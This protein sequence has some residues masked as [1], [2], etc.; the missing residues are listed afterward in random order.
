MERVIEHIIR[1]YVAAVIKMR[2]DKRFSKLFENMVWKIIFDTTNN[3][4]TVEI[5][6]AIKSTCSDHVIW[7]SKILIVSNVFI[8]QQT[9][10]RLVRTIKVRKF[11][12]R[13]G[14]D[15]FQ[16]KGCLDIKGGGQ[17]PLHTVFEGKLT[18]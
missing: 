18:I 6:E 2:H 5:L 15:N 11:L 3:T 7:L 12:K 8:K 17:I 14:Y 9:P 1:P 10:C 16:C 4:T 13:V